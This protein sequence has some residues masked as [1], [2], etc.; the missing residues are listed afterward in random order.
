MDRYRQQQEEKLADAKKKKIA[1]ELKE[2]KSKPE[3][4]KKSKKMQANYVPIYDRVDDIIKDKKEHLNKINADRRKQEHETFTST[5]S[6]IPKSHYKK[7]REMVP[8]ARPNSCTNQWTKE[9]QDKKK[10]AL[11]RKRQDLEEEKLRRELQND[12]HEPFKPKIDPKSNKIAATQAA[13]KSK[14]VSERLYKDSQKRRAQQEA[15]SKPATTSPTT[16]HINERSRAMKPKGD[17]GSRLYEQGL[18]KERQRK[19]AES[20]RWAKSTRLHKPTRL[21]DEEPLSYTDVEDES[22]PF[23]AGVYMLPMAPSV[24]TVEEYY[25]DQPKRS[26]E[27]SSPPRG[28]DVV[29]FVPYDPQYS[30]IF[31]F[32]RGGGS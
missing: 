4:S 13:W 19:N 32:S 6:D 9:F 24:P 11:D 5:P 27:A 16:L 20:E 30:D 8:R 26:P 28:T 2:M 22:L 18:N 23:G 17:V 25:Y 29:N 21:L 12:G 1:E 31:S 15:R 14:E 3:I 10:E 7:N